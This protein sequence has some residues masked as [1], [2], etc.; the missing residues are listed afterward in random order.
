MLKRILS[1][2]L[3]AAVLIVPLTQGGCVWVE[4]KPKPAESTET[5][6]AGTGSYQSAYDHPVQ[7]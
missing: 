4:K 3:L 7:Q 6:P 1:V 5:V 2:L